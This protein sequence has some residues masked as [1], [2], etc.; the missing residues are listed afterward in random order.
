MISRS[1]AGQHFIYG[2]SGLALGF[3]LSRIG[4]TNFGQVHGMFVFSHLRLLY[5][6]A[7]AVGLTMA[8][9]M[10]FAR[11]QNIPSKPF[12][13]G[14]I[15]GSILFGTGWALT[16]SCPAVAIVQLGEGQLAA[17]FTLLG[18]LFGVWSYRQAHAQLFHWDRGACE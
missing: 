9:F 17:A 12:H 10:I 6:F 5:T 16:G 7:G 8:G 2:L 15:P 18:I 3:S 4:F 11:G 13:P 14:T 1:S